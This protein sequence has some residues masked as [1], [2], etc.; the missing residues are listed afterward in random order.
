MKRLV[1]LLMF[2][3]SLAF[4]QFA[5]VRVDISNP[6]VMM[7]IMDLGIALDHATGRS[8]V[9]LDFAISENEM[10]NLIAF[11][12]DFEIL[13][14]DLTSHYQNRFSEM[15]E[16]EFDFG[17]MGGYYTFSEIENKLDEMH[18]DYPNLVSQKISI[19][20]SHEGRDIWAIRISDNPEIS[21]GEPQVLYNALHHAREPQGMMTL[22]YFAFHLLENYE[23]DSQIRY[24]VDNRE[25]WLMPCV[26]PDGYVYN[27]TVQPSGGGMH[28][29]NRRPNG[30]SGYDQGIDLNRN[31]GYFWGYDD[32]GSSPYSCE[33]TYR[34]TSDFSEPETAAFRDFVESHDFKLS[35]NY[36]TYSNLWI[37]PFGYSSS[38]YPPEPDLSI[39]R[40]F[41][42]KMTEVNGYAMGNA[43]ETVGYL[44]NGTTSDWLYG[45]L[46]MITFTPEVGGY[47]DG[48]WP[49][50]SRIVPLAEENL[51]ANI[52]TAQVA[53]GK[54]ELVD[55]AAGSDVLPGQECSL[56]IVC[57]N[58]GLSSSEEGMSI[59]FSS[60]SNFISF[61]DIYPTLPSV[62]PR[63]E[64]VVGGITAQI[65]S[66]A[67]IGF[68][69]PITMSVHLDGEIISEDETSLI[70]GV[71]ETLFS[72]SFENGLSNWDFSGW[73]LT[74]DS[75]SGGNAIT[76]SPNGDYND[77][78][79]STITIAEPIDLGESQ[80]VFLSF[81]A[82]WDIESSW[83]FAQVKISTNGTSWIPVAGMFTTM[84][85]GQGVQPSG[86]P[87]YD[88][89]HTN[90]I[91][92]KISLEDYTEN[93][94]IWVQF[95]FYSDT[96][97]TG[98]GWTIDEFM[99]YGFTGQQCVPCDINED[100]IVN[101]LDVVL[102]VNFIIGV[103]EP[104]DS[105]ACAA[106]FNDDGIINVLDV[107]SIVNTIFN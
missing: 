11:G 65:A 95:S 83:D 105:Q 62:Q 45:E 55:F 82:K 69:I 59:Q 92:E 54:I 53:G 10:N 57:K 107:V 66:E 19:G 29:K 43:M 33:S 14:D 94:Y 42:G 58:V 56:S 13:I 47:S 24:L 90:W 22:F 25:I 77:N 74:T 106:D 80:S 61:P 35:L 98:D 1:L 34:G 100:G 85:S 44:A 72:D 93:A 18:T 89:N 2:V 3:S 41:G 70:I 8:G 5:L 38:A 50:T 6:E 99:I 37:H 15:D 91:V 68:V 103:S 48:F 84:G 49:S 64:F 73:F 28:R 30:C 67:P 71:Q 60:E 102:V 7:Q 36:H 39:F 31:Y 12:I 96:Y 27:Q 81:A 17:S 20:I 79:T 23:T 101:I 75:Y 51:S 4:A 76:E 21:E 63:D 9:Y 88:G 104:T 40:E 87:G 97:V 78:T 52:F 26:N 46:G 32:S 16:R 86:E